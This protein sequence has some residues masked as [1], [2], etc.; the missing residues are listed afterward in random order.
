[1]TPARLNFGGTKRPP[2][3]QTAADD[4]TNCHQGSGPTPTTVV[5]TLVSTKTDEPARF[6]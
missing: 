5:P 2:A 1:M 4:D 6:G 3:E